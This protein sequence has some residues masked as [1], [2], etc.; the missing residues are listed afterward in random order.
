MKCTAHKKR[1]IL[2]KNPLSHRGLTL[3]CPLASRLT[4]RSKVSYAFPSY[5]GIIRLVQ[6]SAAIRAF[7][8]RNGQVVADRLEMRMNFQC[9]TKTDR[10]LPKLA[11]GHM[12]KPLPGSSAEVIGIARQIFLAFGDRLS[13]V[14]HHVAHGNALVPSFSQL[15]NQLDDP[16]E[17]DLRLSKSSL[18]HCLHSGSK[19]RVGL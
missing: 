12:A 16:A 19:N 4:P 5:A 2:A 17:Q 10:R 8:F 14:C 11:D 18:L 3:L 7:G 13:E 6:I 15:Q 9:A 1:E